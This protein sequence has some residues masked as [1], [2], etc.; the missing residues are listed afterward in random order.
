VLD[1]ITIAFD[2]GGNEFHWTIPDAIFVTLS[3]ATVTSQ[4]RGHGGVL[5][6]Q[7]QTTV[8]HR[9]GYCLF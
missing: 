8:C 3:L 2:A 9:D 1:C 4:P 5:I 7:T 6:T